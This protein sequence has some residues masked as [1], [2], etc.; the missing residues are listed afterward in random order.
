M[1]VMSASAKKTGQKEKDERAF[2]IHPKKPRKVAVILAE[3]KAKEKLAI[4]MKEKRAAR[5][6][7]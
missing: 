5:K 3:I 7:R 6:R 4:A 1:I 2:K